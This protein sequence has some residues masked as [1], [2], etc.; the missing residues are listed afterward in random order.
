MNSNSKEVRIKLK[1]NSK[2]SGK[3]VINVE[4]IGKVELRGFIIGNLIDV[5]KVV[6]LD[7]REF[8]LNFLFKVIIKPRQTFEQLSRLPHESIKKICLGWLI[9]YYPKNRSITTIK[10][11]KTTE[12][13]ETFKT[14]IEN[15][16]QE[17]IELLRSNIIPP[18][19]NMISEFS[20]HAK[21]LGLE[22]ILKN[23]K[24]PKGNIL[25]IDAMKIK[26]HDFVKPLLGGINNMSN[27]QLLN[28]FKKSLEIDTK[29][30]DIFREIQK[31][32]SISPIQKALPTVDL[33]SLRSSS[34]ATIEEFIKLKNVSENVVIVN[35]EILKELK[36]SVA[37]QNR[38]EGIILEFFKKQK[39]HGN[40]LIILTIALVV[41]AFFTL[42]VLLKDVIF[43]TLLKALFFIFN[44]SI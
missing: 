27:D 33:R 30:T 26:P 36:G 4:N 3:H 35:K 34:A 21:N 20:N 38:L 9:W 7:S 37:N 15:I 32:L 19:K 16:C 5:Q 22:S 43:N 6:E 29:F 8:T 10:S 25:A 42:I 23:I 12:F 24:L 13:Y 2:P 39:L 40:W 44:I 14:T 18:I 17:E 41:I 28:S 31:S 1:I 11:S